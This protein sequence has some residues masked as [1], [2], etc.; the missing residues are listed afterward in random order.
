MRGGWAS[1]AWVGSP[2]PPER[3]GLGFA[4]DGGRSATFGVRPPNILLSGNPASMCLSYHR[5]EMASES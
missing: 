5:S 3:L 2:L 1:E 4:A